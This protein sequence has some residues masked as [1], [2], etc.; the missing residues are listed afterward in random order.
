[1]IDFQKAADIMLRN[2][3]FDAAKFYGSASS[4]SIGAG[5]LYSGILFSKY[6]ETDGVFDTVEGMVYVLTHEC[7]I[8][9]L[10]ERSFNKYVLICP[11]I[12]F[13]DWVTEFIDSKSEGQLFGFIPDI[14][15][16]NVYRVF[17]LPPI[18]SHINRNILP[19]GGL[20]YLNQI[21]ST[22]INCFRERS[23]EPICALS[24]YG[25]YWIDQ[26]LQNH[27]F[28]PKDK[29]QCLPRFH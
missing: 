22:H 3:S 9:Q 6:N 21:T 2:Y 23:A 28:R 12:K 4:L 7:D 26:K 20:I 17:Y 14:A 18:P 15:K 10:N 29:D 8:S 11:I 16:N 27:L 5:I 19:F 1:M 25:A 24:T 13:D